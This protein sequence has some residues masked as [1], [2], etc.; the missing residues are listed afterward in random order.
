[1]TGA[2]SVRAMMNHVVGRDCDRAVIRRAS[3]TALNRHT[4]TGPSSTRGFSSGRKEAFE[5]QPL[6]VGTERLYLETVY[7]ASRTLAALR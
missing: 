5:L 3:K 6:A 1:M 2:R 4:K 7:Q